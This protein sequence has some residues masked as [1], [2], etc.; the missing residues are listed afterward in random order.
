MSAVQLLEL[1]DFAKI[2]DDSRVAKSRSRRGAATDG[3]ILSHF[4]AGPENRLVAFVC[5][6]SE[7]LA[8]RGNPLL[9]VGPSG[10]GKS[11]LARTVAARQAAMS[12]QGS[13]IH[14]TATE[15]ARRFAEAVDRDSIDPFRKPIRECDVL[16][17]EDIHLIVD[18]PAAQDE[19]ASRIS[20]RIEHSRLTIMT[21]RRIPTEIR[22]LRPLLASRMLPGL[23]LPVAFPAQETRRAILRSIAMRLE[24]NLDEETLAI[25]ENAL[26]TGISVPRL[27]AAIE[28]L[29]LHKKLANDSDLTTESASTTT[30][31]AIQAAI[32]SSSRE[33]NL[34]L[35][36]IAS[37][38]AKKFKLKSADFRGPTRRQ[39]VVRARSLAMY[40]ARKLT[41]LSL[42][43]I[44]LY[45]GGR[46]HTTVMHACRTTETILADSPELAR[47]ADEIVESLLGNE[48]L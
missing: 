12:G 6:S 3:R 44:G 29:R 21:C 36:E 32:E 34:S 5:S 30:N 1:L 20:Q 9:L 14:I 19:L 22:G 27:S 40:L 23:L 43:Q 8:N 38:V 37:A 33:P 35:N 7:S 17:I 2:S 39:Q 48:S 41:D 45:F 4:Y 46:D 16:L 10:V 24:A 47:T 11:E 25:L 15:F 13:V 26:P 18:K 28:Q 31:Q 42:Q